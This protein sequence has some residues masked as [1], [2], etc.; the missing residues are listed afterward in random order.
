M[1]ILVT[2]A[3]DGIGLATARALV[4]RGER[5]IVHGRTEEKATRAA[6]ALRHPGA[7]EPAAAW[8]D[9]SRLADVVALG[10]RLARDHADLRV[11][12]HNAGVFVTERQET[13]DG[14][15]LTF[16]VNHLAP[17]A[18]TGPLLPILRAQ[19]DPRVV[20]VASGAH[21]GGALHFEDLMSLRS[22]EGYRA[23]ATSKLCN[24]LFAN[25]LARREPAIAVNSLH[26]G[27][28]ATKLLRTGFGGGGAPLEE[29]ARTSVHVATAPELRGVSGR[30][31]SDAREAR[32]AALT[33]D[34][35][36]Q[37][38]LWDVSERLVAA[39][40]G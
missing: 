28:I 40:R 14:H 10:E 27:V 33:R 19:R 34:V 2:G 6:Q 21:Q 12:I 31:F 3:T 24:I 25:A 1:S 26:P 15:E 7:P 13:A 35:T 16:A 18:L 8:A 9:F 37:D 29:G 30:Y 36:V 20:V 17:F 22:Y 39:A 32:P 11:V 5:V 4:Q 38:R 23:Y